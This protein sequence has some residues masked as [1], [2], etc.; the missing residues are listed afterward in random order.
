MKNTLYLAWQ[1]RHG[2][3]GAR[4]A[5]RQWFPVG[6]LDASGS[7]YRFRYIRGAEEAREKAGFQPL[8]AFPELH[9]DYRSSELFAVFRNRVPSRERGDYGAMLERLGL[10]AEAT[11]YEILAVSGGKRQTDNLEVFPKIDKRM[12]GSFQCRFFLHGWRHVSDVARNRLVTMGSGEELRIAVELNNPASGVALQLQTADEYHMLGWAPR[13]L[14]AD[15]LHA[16]FEAPA[17]LS[18]CVARINLPPAPH[19]QRVL[20]DMRGHLPGGVEPMSSEQFQP[21]VA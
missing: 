9:R 15:L 8:D 12:D 2:V 19:N 13:Y 11:P 5:S 20:I 3:P 16:V 6:R 21:L 10:S 1:D 17:N 7:G 14:I 4:S 18:A